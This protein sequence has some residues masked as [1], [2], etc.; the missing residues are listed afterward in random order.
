MKNSRHKLSWKSMS[1]NHFFT[2]IIW[3]VTIILSNC[4]NFGRATASGLKDFGDTNDLS[5][6]DS[7]TSFNKNDA[8]CYHISQH[9]A[10]PEPLY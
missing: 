6:L 4:V 3:K 2:G 8:D 1:Y 10:I 9:I 5:L 7:W